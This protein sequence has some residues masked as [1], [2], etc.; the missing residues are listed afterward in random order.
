MTGGSSQPSHCPF[1]GGASASV[2][3]FN[4]VSRAIWHLLVHGLHTLT[5]VFYD[6]CSCF[7]V[8]PLTA[9]TAKALD[10]FL[11]IL[12]WKHAVQ[13]EG[14]TGFSLEMQALGIQYNLSE[15]WRGE[16]TVRNKQGRRDRIVSLTA[17]PRELGR[18]GARSAAAS[19]AGIFN[20][21]GG[22]VFGHV[23]KPAPPALSRCA[24]GDNLSK[25][26]T[27]EMCDLS[28]SLVDASKPRRISMDRDLPSIIVYTDGAFEASEGGLA[29]RA[30]SRDVEVALSTMKRADW[31]SSNAAALRPPCFCFYVQY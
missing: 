17:E 15:R 7:K 30:G 24:M 18:G 11:N 5:C 2:F 8:E 27:N 19:P 1:L 10:T 20:F 14:A 22:F 26:A 3:A 29:N 25:A 21:C 9:L 28:G 13:G 6:D 23:L 16:L 12:G 4:K 31:A